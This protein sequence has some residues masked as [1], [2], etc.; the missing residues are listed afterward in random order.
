[1]APSTRLGARPERRIDYRPTA[2]LGS[3]RNPIVLEDTPPPEEPTARPTKT[4]DKSAKKPARD[5]QGRFIKSE[6]ST[7]PKEHHK[8]VEKT[9]APPKPKKPARPD[10]TECIICAAT[11]STKRNFKASGLEGTCEHFES[12]CDLCIQKQIKT[13][14]SAR[15]LTEAQMP[16]MF[17]ECNTVLDHTELNKILPKALFET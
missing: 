11:K 14:M 9:T 3:V 2:R 5:A 16:C 1:M 10:K 15:Q 8:K 7:K 17:P 12:V 6:T 13:M 4:K